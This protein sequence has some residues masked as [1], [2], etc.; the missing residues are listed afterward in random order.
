MDDGFQ[1]YSIKKNLNILCSTKSIIGNGLVIYLVSRSLCTKNA[2]IVIIN[3]V[4]K[5]SFEEKILKLNNKI[6]F[7]IVIM[8]H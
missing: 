3:G 8:N 6:S 2:Q 5:I 7:F 4:K 1:D